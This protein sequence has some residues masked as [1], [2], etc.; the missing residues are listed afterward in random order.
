MAKLKKTAKTARKKADEL[1]L[2]STQFLR[3]VVKSDAKAEAAK[4]KPAAR[5]DRFG[6]FNP[7]D[8]S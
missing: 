5:K 4:Q 7:Y 8:N 2:A 3:K 6:G 1:S